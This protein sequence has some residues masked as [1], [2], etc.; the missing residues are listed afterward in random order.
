MKLRQVLLIYNLLLP[1]ALLVGLPRYFIKAIQRGGARKNF[2]QRFG[3]YDQALLDRWQQEGSQRTWIHAVSVGEVLVGLKVIQAFLDADPELRLVLS[4][5][6]PTG[7]RLAKDECPN[8]VCV[9][10]NPVDLPW[11][12]RG[13][14][15]RIQPDHLILVEAEVWPNLVYQAQSR[16]GE[17]IIGECTTVGTL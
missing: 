13:A 4:T 2:A 6:T 5:T 16:G 12:G 9:I 15:N 8:S 1:L 3:R 10:Y 14:L 7:Y 17:G 11:V